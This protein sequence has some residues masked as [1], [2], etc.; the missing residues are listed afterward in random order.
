MDK[1]EIRRR[2]QEGFRLRKE[3]GDLEYRKIKAKRRREYYDQMQE[4]GKEVLG[5]KYTPTMSSAIGPVPQTKKEKPRGCMVG[6]IVVDE[7]GEHVHMWQAPSLKGTMALSKQNLQGYK[8]AVFE[9]FQ[10]AFGRL[11]ES[12]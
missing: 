3:L 1:D 11:A 12:K 10:K 9:A 4:T 7:S 5:E 8:E 6:I 2:Q